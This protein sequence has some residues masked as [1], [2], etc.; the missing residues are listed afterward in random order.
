[1]WGIGERSR[2]RKRRIRPHAQAVQNAVKRA[3]H[4]G[5][6]GQPHDLGTAGA[7]GVFPEHQ[8]DHRHHHQ[9]GGSIQRYVAELAAVN[10]ALENAAEQSLPWKDHFLLV[11]LRYFREILRLAEHQLGDARRLCAAN[12]LPPDLVAVAQHIAGAAR[13]GFEFGV[14][15]AE[16]ARNVL[17]DHGLEQFFLAG[18]IQKQ[19]AL[20]H[21]GA[22]GHF[23]H[24]RGGIALFHKQVERRV[25][26]LPGARLFAAAAL[27]AGLWAVGIVGDECWHVND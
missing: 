6:R 4:I 24:P 19:R 25:Q 10:A 14:P 13:H 8:K 9:I 11:E 2:G 23:I 15:L 21:P 7:H 22:R 27:G 5:L 3:I 1:M 17:A 18:E 20:G 26:Q 16:P 12:T